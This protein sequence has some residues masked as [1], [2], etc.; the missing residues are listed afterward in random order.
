MPEVA[1]MTALP[2][3]RGEAVATHDDGPGCRGRALAAKGAVRRARLGGKGFLL[4]QLTL[5]PAVVFVS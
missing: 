1:A 3:G 5:A 4:R 2:A